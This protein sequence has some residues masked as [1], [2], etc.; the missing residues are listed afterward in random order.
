[1]GKLIRF[2]ANVVCIDGTAYSFRRTDNGELFTIPISDIHKKVC[3]P[4]QLLHESGRLKIGA[5]ID[6]VE[7]TNDRNGKTNYY[8]STAIY[9]TKT[10]K[11]S[12]IN[13][14][15]YA[16][17]LLNLID[18]AHELDTTTERSIVYAISRN[19]SSL[20]CSLIRSALF[21]NLNR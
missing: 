12:F 2:Y 20:A 4:D 1:M 8:P 3:F 5:T 14:D 21:K 10:T 9:Q 16:A 13:S 7:K 6:F 18:H 17:L 15:E 19:N 11:P